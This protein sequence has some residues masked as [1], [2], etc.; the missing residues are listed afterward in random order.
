MVSVIPITPNLDDDDYTVISE[1]EFEYIKFVYLKHIKKFDHY[2]IYGKAK[3]VKPSASSTLDWN[4]ITNIIIKVDKLDY[5]PQ[6]TT[7]MEVYNTSTTKKIAI[8]LT[9]DVNIL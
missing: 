7:L 1:S 8:R 5:I 2:E 6:T 3:A 4:G 9:F